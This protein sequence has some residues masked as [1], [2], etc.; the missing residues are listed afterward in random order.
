V[1]RHWRVDQVEGLSPEAEQ[2][3]ERVLAH[4]QRVGQVARRQAERQSRDSA[5]RSQPAEVG[6]S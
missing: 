1:L 2:A 4:V 6:R 5:E 3:R